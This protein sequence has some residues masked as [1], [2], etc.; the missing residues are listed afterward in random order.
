MSATASLS[1]DT[2]REP[3]CVLEPSEDETAIIDFPADATFQILRKPP[4]GMEPVDGG[5]VHISELVSGDGD[6]ILVCFE[7]MVPSAWA[8]AREHLRV[9]ANLGQVLLV[10]AIDSTHAMSALYGIGDSAGLHGLTNQPTR[11]TVFV[12]STTL[13]KLLGIDRSPTRTRNA[14]VHIRQGCVVASWVSKGDGDKPHDWTNILASI[15]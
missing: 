13:M 4:T 1:A 10:A 14:L 15:G 12:P 3:T 5:Q 11:Q 9:G 8:S 6:Y 7:S 2:M